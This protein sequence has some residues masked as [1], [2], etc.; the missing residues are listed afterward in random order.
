MDEKIPRAPR[1]KRKTKRLHAPP[2]PHQRQI[3]NLRSVPKKRRPHLPILF[4][5]TPLQ[6][7]KRSRTRSTSNVRIPFH[8]QLRFQTYRIFP[9][10]RSLWR[11]LTKTSGISFTSISSDYENFQKVAPYKHKHK[12]RSKTK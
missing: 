6:I 7:S 11:I 1:K 12:T 3:N 2:Q 9:G 8:F 4:H 10:A 5:R